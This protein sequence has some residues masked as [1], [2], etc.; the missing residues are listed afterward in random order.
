M[1]TIENA[2]M[3]N[4]YP[5][6]AVANQWFADHGWSVRSQRLAITA[7]RNVKKKNTQQKQTPKTTTK[8]NIKP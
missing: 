5:K 1:S 7:L 8:I 2:T 6:A 3:L 4:K